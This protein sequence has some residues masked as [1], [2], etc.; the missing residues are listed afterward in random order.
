MGDDI[1]ETGWTSI[2]TILKKYCPDIRSLIRKE[3]KLLNKIAKKTVSV[4]FNQTC[5][6]EKLL[7]K[8]TIYMCIYMYICVCIYMYICVCVCIYVYLQ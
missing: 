1:P 3:E 7:P 8:Y 6:K 5:I 2:G 4:V